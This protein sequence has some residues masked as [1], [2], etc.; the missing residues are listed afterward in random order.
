MSD[1]PFLQIA[2]YSF[3]LWFGA[4]LLVQHFAKP[5]M[6]YTGLGL[7]AYALGLGIDTLLAST[8]SSQNADLL[9]QERAVIVLLPAIFWFA[10]VRHLIPARARQGVPRV[11]LWAVIVGSIMFG[12][13]VSIA[14]IPQTLF[15]SDLVMLAVGLDLAILSY[16][17]A[18]LDAYD[19]GEVLWRDLLRSFGASALA[20]LIFGGQVVLAMR[21]TGSDDGAMLLLLLAVVSTAILLQT[22]SDPVQGLLDRVLLSGRPGL[23]RERANLRAVASALPRVDD[24]LEVSRI[25]EQEFTQ[26]T[27]RALSHMGDLRRLATNPLTRLPVIANRLAA[28]QQPD[29]TLERAAELKALLTESIERLKPRQG[30]SGIS[31]EWRYYNALYYPYVLGIKPYSVRALHNGDGEDHR[32]V[33]DWFRAQVPERTLHNWQNAAAALVAQDLRERGE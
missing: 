6:R 15:A 31:D 26:L 7:I 3:A 4:Y 33:L 23:Q 18:A 1:L 28:R 13:S 30:E 20:A 25:S 9:R 2:A 24:S 29:S 16:G 22:L 10:A 11:P 8:A 19:E 5:G 17:I 21:I 12:L 14:L 27:R 32:A